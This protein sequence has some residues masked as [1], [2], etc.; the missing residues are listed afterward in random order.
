MHSPLFKSLSRHFTLEEV[1]KGTVVVDVL[2]VGTVGNQTTQFLGFLVLFTSELGEA[3]LV[4]NDNLLTTRELVLATTEGFDDGGLVGILGTDRD[5]DLTDIDTSDSTDGLTEGTTHT[6]LQTIGT[7]TRQHLVDTQ[8]VERMDTNTHVE[9]ILTGNL[10]NVL[11]G[12]NTGSFQG[13]AGN[14]FTFVR[15]QVDTERELVT[16]GSLATKIEDADLGVRDTT[17]ETGLGVRLVLAITIAAS[18]T[19]THL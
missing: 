18:R 13:F 3:P 9:V 2:D 11:V 12:S 4:G 19:A 14:L 15:D 17:T 10:A 6:G 7:G 5:Q 8:N 16:A 1:S